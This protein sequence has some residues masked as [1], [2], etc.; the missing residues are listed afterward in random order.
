LLKAIGAPFV[1]E[2]MGEGESGM[3]VVLR[4]RITGEIASALL[5]NIYDIEYYGAVWWEN[6]EAAEQASDKVLM[7]Y[8]Y[9]EASSWEPIE[10]GEERLRLMN[11]KLNN[12]SRRRIVL[13]REGTITVRKL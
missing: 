6:K 7:E 5:R 12:D 3:P 13:D 8:G 4:H 9:A 2:R 1:Y 11:V 10:I